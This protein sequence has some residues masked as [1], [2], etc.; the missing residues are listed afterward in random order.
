M[1]CAPAK[2]GDNKAITMAEKNDKKQK[3]FL[4]I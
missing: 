1:G 2:R 4:L 3:S